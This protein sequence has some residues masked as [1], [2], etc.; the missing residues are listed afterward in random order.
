[1]STRCNI[2]ITGAMG[3]TLYLYRHHDG[4]LSET[5]KHVAEI[6]TRPIDKWSRSTPMI[7]ARFLRHCYEVNEGYDNEARPIYELTDAAHGDINFFYHVDVDADGGLRI[8]YAK[9]HGS[10]LEGKT[11]LDVMATF[12][13]AINRDID[14]TNARIRGMNATLTGED[15]YEEVELLATKGG[16]NNGG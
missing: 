2:K 3:P 13:D 7:A 12:V 5:G 8:G 1:M 4:Y 14:D 6:M 11:P 15:R 16:E 10:E 9:G